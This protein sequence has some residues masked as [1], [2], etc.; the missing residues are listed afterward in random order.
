MIMLKYCIKFLYYS[1]HSWVMT[2]LSHTPFLAP[3]QIK[4]NKTK[5]PSILSFLTTEQNE[6]RNTD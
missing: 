3:I 5:I 1:N 2:H 6:K 4:Q